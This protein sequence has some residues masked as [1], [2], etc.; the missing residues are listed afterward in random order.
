MSDDVAVVVDG[1]PEVLALSAD[2]HEQLVEMPS[3]A[4]GADATSQARA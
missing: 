2:R 4:H 1:A 3:V